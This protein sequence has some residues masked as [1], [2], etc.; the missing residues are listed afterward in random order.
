MAVTATKTRKAAPPT[1]PMTAPTLPSPSTS[2]A[3]LWVCCSGLVKLPSLS[4]ESS[5]REMA[6]EGEGGEGE[7][8]GE[9]DG[10]EGEVVGEMDGDDGGHWIPSL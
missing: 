6:G 9:M 5:E 7:V 4:G 2:L 10:D 3:A 1:A 8:V